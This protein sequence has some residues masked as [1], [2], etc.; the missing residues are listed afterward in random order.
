M[1]S[2]LIC[3]SHNLI[4][5]G[6][7]QRGWA[8]IRQHVLMAHRPR[9]CT[10]DCPVC[11]G[12]SALSGDYRVDC[13]RSREAIVSEDRHVVGPANHIFTQEPEA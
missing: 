8:R 10:V 2:R 9:P 3:F 1:R 7:G 11:H 12:F 4:V 13:P 5:G 6:D